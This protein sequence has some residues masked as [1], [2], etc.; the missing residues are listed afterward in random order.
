M[1]L[2]RFSISVAAS[3]SLF[4]SYPLDAS[5]PHPHP[6]IVSFFGGICLVL[7]RWPVLGLLSQCYGIVYL[8]GQFFPIAANAVRDVPVVGGLVRMKWVEGVVEKVGGGRRSA[9]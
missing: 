9:V 5:P 1:L 8:F 6:G 4:I 2:E 3:V 7:L